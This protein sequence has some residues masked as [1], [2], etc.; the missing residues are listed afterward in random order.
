[1]FGKSKTHRW[2]VVFFVSAT[3][4]LVLGF[5]NGTQWITIAFGEIFGGIVR[6][7]VKDKDSALNKHLEAKRDAIKAQSD[8][9][10]AASSNKL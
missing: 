7:S 8:A 4:L 10:L 5:L 9:A 2:L 6:D 1:M 3:L